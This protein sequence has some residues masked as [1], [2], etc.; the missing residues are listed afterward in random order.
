MPESDVFTLYN[1]TSIRDRI[2]AWL[3]VGIGGFVLSPIALIN[4]ALWLFVPAVPLLVSGLLLHQTHLRIIVDH[5]IGVV[6][7][8]RL[9]FGLKLCQRQHPLSDIVGLDLRRVAGDERERPS[10]TW[11]LRLQLHTAS[12]TS[13]KATPRTRTYVIGVYNSHLNAL[14]AQHQLWQALRPRR[15]R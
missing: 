5:R 14:K 1:D 8:S 3:L 15:Q 13:G 6:S 2:A 10:D 4:R 9:L 12:H 11:Y 7:I